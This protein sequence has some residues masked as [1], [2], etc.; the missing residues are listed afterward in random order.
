MNPAALVRNDH[1]LVNTKDKAEALLQR[2]LN[3]IAAWIL[4]LDSVMTIGPQ[5]QNQA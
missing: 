2:K 5:T 3:V 1:H 4:L